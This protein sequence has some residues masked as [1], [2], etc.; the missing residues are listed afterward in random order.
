LEKTH[1]K[2]GFCN[3]EEG[4]GS[5][6]YDISFF[7]KLQLPWFYLK[8]YAKNP[9]YFNESVWDTVGAFF[10][11][12]FIKHDYIFLYHYI[13][14][15]EEEIN[16]TLINLYDWELSP[17]TPTT[18]RIGDGTAAFYNYI[19][20]G[21]AG[22]TENDTLRSNQIREGHLSREEALRRVNLENRPRW[23]SI[24]W[25]CDTIGIDMNE[26]IRRINQAPKVKLLQG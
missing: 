21:M 19:Y 22:I 10:S 12:Y 20:Y 14:W 7:K 23:E 24:R 11:A 6:Y 8:N 16:E 26:A 3:I 18:W 1:F 5:I 13:P 25:Y 4:G 17:D 2:T 15:N 9:A